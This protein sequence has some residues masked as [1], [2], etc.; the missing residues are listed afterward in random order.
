MTWTRYRFKA[1]AEDPRPVFFPP[2][3]PY[4]ITGYGDGYATV[5]CY[6]PSAEGDRALRS[7]WPEAADVESSPRDTIVYSDRFPK[8]SWWKR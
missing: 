7:L 5:I 3:G 8:P 2:T 4:W 6:L 1:N